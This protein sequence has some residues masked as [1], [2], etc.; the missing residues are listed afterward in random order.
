MLCLCVFS[1]LFSLF[2]LSLSLSLALFPSEA[3]PGVLLASQVAV[4][5]KVSDFITTLIREAA[6]NIAGLI[7]SRPNAEHITYG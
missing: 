7:T 6:F 5:V 1:S 3:G 4:P 2:P